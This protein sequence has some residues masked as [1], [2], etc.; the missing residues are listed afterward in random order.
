MDLNTVEQ[1]NLLKSSANWIIY[2][3]ISPSGKVYVGITTLSPERR[4]KKGKG[5]RDNTY[6]RKAIKKYGWDNFTHNIIASNL[7]EATAKNMEKDLIRFNKKKGISY[8]I[9]AGGDGNSKVCSEETK[10]KIS[11]ASKGRKSYPRTQEWRE[12]MSKAMKGKC[13]L[14]EED[15]KKAHLHSKI[16]LSKK[17]LQ[18]TLTDELIGEYSGIREVARLK[19]FD[20]SFIAACC[21]GK[22]KSAYNYKW[23]FKDA[24]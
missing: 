1:R 11:L 24:S 5:Y 18:Y 10:K 12:K 16:K 13:A 9:S 17:V 19:G 23:R 8:N 22:K 14:S 3:H 15:R 2:E 21:R 7:G 6:F 20:F 4:W